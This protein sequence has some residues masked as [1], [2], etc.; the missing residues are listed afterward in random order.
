M[1]D[2]AMIIIAI[3]VYL[4]LDN[5]SGADVTTWIFVSIFFLVYAALIASTISSDL[6]GFF[7]FIMGFCDDGNGL[8]DDSEDSVYPEIQELARRA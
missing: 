2:L 6:K 8:E 3:N 4:V 5:A 1:L 7:R